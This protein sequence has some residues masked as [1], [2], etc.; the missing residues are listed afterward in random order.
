[1]ILCVNN[2]IF[3]YDSVIMTSIIRNVSRELI[4][5]KLSP[6]RKPL[7]LRG[8]RQTGKTYSLLEFGNQHFSTCHVLNFQENPELGSLFV[9][10]LSPAR[11]IENLEFFLNAN[12]NPKTDLVIFDEIQDCPRALTSI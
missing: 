10:T 5:W 6:S 4:K 9:G 2:A 3:R 7:V 8:A 1:M 12:I 11:I